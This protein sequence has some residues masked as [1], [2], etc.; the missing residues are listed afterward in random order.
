MDK[1]LTLVKFMMILNQ[2]V[3]IQKVIKMTE[4]AKHKVIVIETKVLRRNDVSFVFKPDKVLMF[5]SSKLIST[6]T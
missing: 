1:E 3:T 4:T 2:P 6:S 5:L